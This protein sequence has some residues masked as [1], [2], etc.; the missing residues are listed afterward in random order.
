MKIDRERISPQPDVLG[1]FRKFESIDAPLTIAARV[2]GKIRSAFSEGPP[3]GSSAKKLEH[4]KSSENPI[5]VIVVADT[6]ILQD[7]L[8]VEVQEL[9]GSKLLEFV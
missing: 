4:L 5:N 7:I 3:D 2:T 6:D 9:L 8:W 1:L